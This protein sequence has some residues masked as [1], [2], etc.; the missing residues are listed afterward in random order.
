[1]DTDENGILRGIGDLCP[2]FQGHKVITFAG[3]DNAQPFCLEQRPQLPRNIQ[4]KILFITITADRAFVVTS[5]AR[6]ENYGL[7]PADV[8]N[9][10]G[11][12]LRLNCFGHVHARD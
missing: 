10:M 9:A 2:N 12:K 7:E 8:W 4:R 1:M 5:M 6:I 11:T 3:H